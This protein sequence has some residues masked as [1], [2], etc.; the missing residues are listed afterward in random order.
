MPSAAR[1]RLRKSCPFDLPDCR[2]RA[3]LLMLF[4]WPASTGV[5]PTGDV[6]R[7]VL[8]RRSP[9]P[10]LTSAVLRFHRKYG[11][12]RS[13][14]MPWFRNHGIWWD[15]VL[16]YL[17][18]NLSTALVRSGWSVLSSSA[19]Q[20]AAV[21]LRPRWPPRRVTPNSSSPAPLAQLQ[22]L[23]HP[24]RP[25]QDSPSCH[26]RCRRRRSY[27]TDS[28]QPIQPNVAHSEWRILTHAHICTR[29]ANDWFIENQFR[30]VIFARVTT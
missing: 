6:I 27:S 18:R 21:Q 3:P 9:G 17:R 14:Q 12:T 7:C 11:S 2:R 5:C 1:R 25:L 30:I 22:H 28:T 8:Y 29:L 4:L 16:P 20:L 24:S 19:V 26:H 23:T 10:D 15:R 13:H